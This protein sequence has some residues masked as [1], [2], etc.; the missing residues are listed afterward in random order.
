VG[1]P[2]RSNGMREAFVR[3]VERKVHT[4]VWWEN[5]REIEHLEKLGLDKRV[6]FK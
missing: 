4:D 1:I 2:I 6:I 5:L 3:M